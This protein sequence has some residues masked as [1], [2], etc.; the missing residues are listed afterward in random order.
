MS[1]WHWR[2][3]ELGGFECKKRL[4]QNFIFD[5]LLLARIVR[6]AGIEPG[7]VAVEIGAGAGTLTEALARRAGKVY[8]YEIDRE[9]EPALSALAQRLPNVEVRFADVL[10]MTDAEF[11]AVAPCPF[12]LVAN[13]PYCAATRILMRFLTE[14]DDARDMT[15]MLQAEVAERL[16]AAPGTAEYGAL[17]AFVD[18]YA[19]VAKIRDVSRANFRPEPNVDSALVRLEP[20]RFD[21]MPISAA[22]FRECVRAGFRMRRKTL[23][24][25]LIGAFGA[26]GSAVD[27]ALDACGIDGR[28]RGETLS[29]EE[30]VRLSDAMREIARK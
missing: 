5:P 22:A 20:R 19:R 9:L 27:A 16:T 25:N 28:R 26:S 23:R 8:A 12:K 6:D 17:T 21:P 2:G 15:V 29:T 11:K 3:A 30:Y 13:L 14:C 1:D 10:S 18:F 24:N 4:G 7:D